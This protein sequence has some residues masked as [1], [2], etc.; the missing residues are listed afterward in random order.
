VHASYLLALGEKAADIF[1]TF[2]L[3]HPLMDDWL[4]NR[5]IDDRFRYITRLLGQNGQ[6]EEGDEDGYQTGLEILEIQNKSFE[7]ELLLS[8]D[9][10]D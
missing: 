4:C 9:Q 10:I 2:P 5:N 3:T 1:F 8:W 6:T 7:S